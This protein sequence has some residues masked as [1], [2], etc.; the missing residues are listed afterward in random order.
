MLSLPDPLHLA[1]ALVPLAIYLSVIGLFNLLP[2]P[3]VIAGARDALW[4]AMGLSGLVIA[5]PMELFLPQR[6]AMQ[7]GSYV[8]LMMVALYG[9]CS[10]FIILLLRPRLVIYNTSAAEL[11]PILERLVKEIDPAATASDGT[12]VLP[13]QFVKFHVEAVPALR[14]ISLASVGNR[15]SWHTW[16]RL[17]HDLALALRQSP[18]V[19]NPYGLALVSLGLLLATLNVWLLVSQKDLVAQSLR[20]MLRL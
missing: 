19:L 20:D 6:P 17:E 10:I 2:R 14:N 8:W 16:R 4:L 9:L 15:Q 13:T 18:R 3:V 5:G 11:M 1:I 12:F 7:Y